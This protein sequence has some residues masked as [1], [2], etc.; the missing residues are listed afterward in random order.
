MKRHHSRKGIEIGAGD[1][2]PGAGDRLSESSSVPVP[3]SE[4][5]SPAIHS[6]ST[7]DTVPA[8]SITGATK[9]GILPAPSSSRS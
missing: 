4:S 8:G 7:I 6:A 2:W 1:E 5:R 3:V 9:R